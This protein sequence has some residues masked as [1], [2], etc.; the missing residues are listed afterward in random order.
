MRS[1]SLRRLPL[2]VPLALLAS[3]FAV[4]AQERSSARPNDA[5]PAFSMQALR[6]EA[7]KPSLYEIRYTTA[8]TLDTQAELVFEFPAALDL[9]LLEIASST[10]ING[11]FKLTREGSLVRVRRTGL[12]AAIPPGRQVELMLGLITSPATLAGNLEVT[13][14][15]RS[16]SGNAAAGKKSYPIQFVRKTNQ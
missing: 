9:R 11:G 12:G 7:G 6:A 15:Q 2:M 4:I 10:T 8:D 14:M 3:A 16:A 13:F 1:L 5:S